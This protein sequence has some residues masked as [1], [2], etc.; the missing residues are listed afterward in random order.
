M[1]D[2]HNACN[3]RTRTSLKSKWH[4][5][6]KNWIKEQAD[7]AHAATQPP[8]VQTAPVP[9]SADAAAATPQHQ[10]PAAEEGGTLVDVSPAAEP[11]RHAEVEVVEGDF[12]PSHNF[13]AIMS[14]SQ[15]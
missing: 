14:I 10:T 7:S 13:S 12:I 15:P 11:G 1:A 4:N 3:L 2:N 5:L 8:P 6:H 9:P